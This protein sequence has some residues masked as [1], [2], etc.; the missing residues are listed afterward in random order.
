MNL[1]DL[2]DELTKEY[3]LEEIE[4]GRAFRNNFYPLTEYQHL[5]LFNGYVSPKLVEHIPEGLDIENK[6]HMRRY[7]EVLPFIEYCPQQGA[8]DH[9]SKRQVRLLTLVNYLATKIEVL[10][11]EVFSNIVGHA[12]LDGMKERLVPKDVLEKNVSEF[13]TKK[14]ILNAKIEALSGFLNDVKYDFNLSEVE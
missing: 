3:E 8:D 11:Q 12:V 6:D 7:W 14:E 9:I 10:Q 13:M 5:Y 1:E 2:A 4:Y